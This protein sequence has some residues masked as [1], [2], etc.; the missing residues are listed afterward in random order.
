M[1]KKMLPPDED[2]VDQPMNNDDFPN[3]TEGGDPNMIEQPDGSMLI[4]DAGNTEESS[5]FDENLAEKLPETDLAR[6]AIDILDLIEVDKESRKKR[7]ELYEEGLKRTGLGNDT[8]GGAQFEGASRAVHPVLAESCVD[9]AASAIKELFPPDGPVKIHNFAEGARPDEI[10]RAEGKRDFM[11]WQ[12]V[13]EMP[14]YRSDME[15]LLTQQPLGGSQYLKIWWDLNENRP[16]SEFV[17]IDQVYLPFSA[18][19]FA[20]CKR[21]TVVVP[22]TRLEY[23]ERVKSGMYRDLELDDSDPYIPEESSSQKANEK[24]EGKSEPSYNEDGLRNFYEVYIFIEVEEGEGPAPYIITIDEY[25]RKIAAIYRNWDEQDPLKREQEWLV[26]FTFIPWRGA[27]GVGLTHL[28]GSLAGSATGALRALL[29]SAHLNNF[30]GAIKLKGARTSGQNVAISATQITEIEA[31]ANV[32]DIRKTIMPLPFNQPSP[33]LFQL[34]GWITEAAKGVVSTAEEKIADASNTMPVG[35]TMAL[36][37]Q[38]S[39]VFSAIHARLHRSQQK[40]LAIIQRLNFKY[41]D[42]Q[43]QTAKFGRVIVA[44]EDFLDTGNIVPVSDPNI[45]SESQR[46]A[47][48]QAVLQMSQDPMVPWNKIAIYKRMLRLMHVQSPQE[49]IQEPPPPVSADP[50]T[51]IVAAMSGQQVSAQPQMDHMLH[52]KEQLMYLNDPIFGA[53]NPVLTNPGFATILQDTY[54]H[55]IFMF[56]Q[57]KTMAQQQAVGMGQTSMIQQAAAAG[58]P[59]QMVE[60]AVQQAMQQ[61][62]TQELIQSEA[63]RIF[64]EMRQQVEPYVQLLQQAAE[65]VKQKQEANMPVDPAS[66]AAIKI[67]E[68]QETTKAQIAGLRDQNEKMKMDMTNKLDQ[69]QMMFDAQETSRKLQLESSIKTQIEPMLEQMK[70]QNQYMMNRMDNIQHSSTEMSK[71]KDDNETQI[72]IQQM[73]DEA[74][75]DR[76]IIIEQM[77][78]EVS[79]QIAALNAGNAQVIADKNANNAQVIAKTNADNA[80]KI[81]EKNNEFKSKAVA[82]KKTESKPKKPT[83]EPKG[84]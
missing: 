63:M 64:M 31:P 83:N 47:Q 37:E 29:D 54:Q 27:Y 1:A 62:Q 69:Q 84:E 45:F 60:M 11:N 56:Q 34:L 38:G 10:E 9:Y 72:M 33:V 35:T 12:L 22:L 15:I 28:I 73:R 26:D 6:L 18:S 16:C 61:P 81:A 67:A 2:M 49:F 21:R 17:P 7:D 40:V 74:A 44:R 59:P 51:E 39:K 48:I 13:E 68:M 79:K 23:E 78:T 32:D 36:I 41:Y 75:K 25:S 76:A 19:S 8:P 42:E 53:A 52:I 5:V 55:M 4:M 82:E 58:V 20:S 3:I 70:I 77:K 30:P 14:E 80:Q 50:I 71:N 24:I 46:F 57:M 43:K 65:F 66:Q